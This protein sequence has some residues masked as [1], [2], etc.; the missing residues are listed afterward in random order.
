MANHKR[1]LN[2]ENK[3][4]V[5][6]RAGEKGK[7]LMG[8]EESSCWDEDWVLYVSNESWEYTPKAKNTLYTL[9]AS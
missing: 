8:I 1:L 2:T 3:V 7:R 4:R 9:Y 6:G 5:M